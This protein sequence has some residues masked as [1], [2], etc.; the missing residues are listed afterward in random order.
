MIMR[1][2]NTEEGKE[3]APLEGEEDE[4]NLNKP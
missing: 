1:Q 4:E 3:A 2:P